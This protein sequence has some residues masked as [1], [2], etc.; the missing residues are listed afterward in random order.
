MPEPKPKRA[1]HNAGAFVDPSGIGGGIAVPMWTLSDEYHDE[2]AEPE[3][4]DRVP[5]PDP[6]GLA[7]RVVAWLR[8]HSKA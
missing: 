5:E 1:E 4:S 8:G 2:P 6:P 3:D 7:H